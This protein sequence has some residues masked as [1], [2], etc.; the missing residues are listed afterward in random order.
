MVFPLS[1]LLPAPI[2]AKIGHWAKNKLTVIY[3]I[4]W[5]IVFF[6][7]FLIVVPAF[8]PLPL[9][10]IHFYK[11]LTLFSQF[12]FWGIWWPFVLLS[13]VFLGRV[14]CG[15]LCPEG[16]L[17]E[18]ASR[19]GR[20]G[21][22]PHWIRWRGWP[23]VAFAC[24]TIYGQLVS[25][26]QYPKPT[27]LILGGSTLAAIVIGFLY[28]REKRIWCRYLC[29]VNGVFNLMARLSPLHFKVDH[30]AW[31]KFTYDHKITKKDTPNCAP[32][33]PLR[34]MEGASE[35]HMCTRCSGHRDAINLSWRSSAQEIVNFINHKDG[36]WETILIC[37]GLIGLAMGAFHWTRSPWFIDLKQYVA[38]W[39]VNHNILWPLDIQTP[40]WILT[41]YSENNDVF[42]LLDGALIIFYILGTAC[43]VG[44][45][46]LF[47]IINAIFM[48]DNFEWKKVYHLSQSLIPLAGCGVF[49]GLSALTITFLKLEE[50]PLFWVSY[51]RLFFLVTSSLYSLKLGWDILRFYKISLTRQFFAMTWIGSAIVYINIGWWLLFWGW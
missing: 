37:F 14:W 3:Y 4:Q 51:L 30:H 15:V 12:L 34:Q 1:T 35:C 39:L 16:T 40:W 47:L 49:L 9:D 48:I 44:F 50:I 29:P 20:Q 41:S 5:L 13:M 43:S 25:V 10:E 27:L 2:L 26:Y 11:N 46:L 28:G 36:I 19:Y 7:L 33:I 21:A 24:T 23:F 8:L 32:L 22:I 42:N 18:W 6:Y 45:V 31:E 17:T 38:V